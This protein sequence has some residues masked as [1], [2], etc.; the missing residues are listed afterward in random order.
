[1]SSRLFER[2][3]YNAA[4]HERAGFADL[5]NTHVYA[6]HVADPELI[7]GRYRE[8]MS[9][10]LERSGRRAD[11]RATERSGNPERKTVRPAW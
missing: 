3:G 10:G 7:G 8:V 5:L 2:W 4:C 9:E 1:M 6:R 11:A